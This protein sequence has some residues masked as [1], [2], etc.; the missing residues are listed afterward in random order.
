MSLND[1]NDLVRG[2]GKRIRETTLK[3]KICH[4]P[5]NYQFLR[6]EHLK[7]YIFRHNSQFQVRCSCYS[8]PGTYCSFYSWKNFPAERLWQTE[9]NILYLFYTEVVENI[10]SEFNWSNAH[11]IDVCI[12][13]PNIRKLCSCCRNKMQTFRGTGS[14]DIFWQKYILLRI[15]RDLYWFFSL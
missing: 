6:W 5:F 11:Q 14:Q 13:R 4:S 3:S 7:V 9:G 15:N 8:Y 2:L 10:N 1:L 12:W